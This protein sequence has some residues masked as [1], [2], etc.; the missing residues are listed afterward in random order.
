MVER[1]SQLRVV[2]EVRGH[3]EEERVAMELPPPSQKPV[4]A[5]KPTLPQHNQ[6][7]QPPGASL[8]IMVDE[9]IVAVAE[10]RVVL[11]EAA[12]ERE[13]VAAAMS[14][15]EAGIPTPQQRPV[16]PRQPQLLSRVGVTRVQLPKPPAVKQPDVV[17]GTRVL[18][19]S[20]LT[21]TV[22]AVLCVTPRAAGLAVDHVHTT[23]THP[24]PT[25]TLHPS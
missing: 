8:I 15:A 20:P 3:E 16:M 14:D 11:V 5:T 19:H 4:K 22:T 25:S 6:A 7:Q 2:D 1:V 9:E 10:G 12:V 13:E 23:T 17:D 24:S 18:Q 21:A